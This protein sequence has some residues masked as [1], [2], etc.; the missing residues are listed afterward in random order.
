MIEIRQYI[1][2]D[3]MR[4]M[5][6]RFDMVTFL[7]FPDPYEVAVNLSKGPAFTGANSDEIIACG[8]IIPLWKGVGEAWVVT[9]PLV[10]KYPFTFAKIIWRRLRALTDI[11][12]LTRVQTTVD[13]GHEVSIKWLERMGFVNEGEMKRY[14]G[15][16]DFYRYALIKEK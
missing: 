16:R 4:I 12:D 11:M 5:R 9:S 13:A 8:G 6:R 7:N 10:E 3:Y 14:I 2:G 1:P 15:G